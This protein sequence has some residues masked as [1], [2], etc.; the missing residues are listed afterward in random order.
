MEYNYERIESDNGPFN[1]LFE[2]K[3]QTQE[4]T[5]VV[6]LHAAIKLAETF[7]GFGYKRKETK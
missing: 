6:S 2:W 4:T 1:Y 3:N 7:E 5:I